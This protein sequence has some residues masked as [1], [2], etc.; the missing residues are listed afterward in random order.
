MSCGLP[1]AALPWV[2]RVIIPRPVA[3]RATSAIF[4][5]LSTLLAAL[6]V[7]VALLFVLGLLD[8]LQN[9]RWLGLE[10]R[11]RKSPS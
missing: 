11:V 9:P 5:A 1:V 2:V 8:V 4:F 6:L 10:L 3:A 7:I